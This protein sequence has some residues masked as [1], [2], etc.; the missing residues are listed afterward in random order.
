[1]TAVTLRADGT[2]YDPSK[3]SFAWSYSKLKNYEI[4][5]LRHNE[6]DNKKST[7]EDSSDALDWGNRLHKVAA[8]HFTKGTPIPTDCQVLIP[9]IAKIKD[10]PGTISVERKY[11]LTRDLSPCGYFGKEVWYRGVA[12]VLKLH[13]DV[14]LAVDWKSGKIV[15]DSVQLALM[16]SCI[17]A[18]HPEVQVIR[19]EFIWLGHECTTQQIF[20]RR[21]MPSL[22][23]DLSPRVARL[24]NSFN[25]GIY[26]PTPN[27]MCA[28]YCRVTTCQHHG[29]RYA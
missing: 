16:A 25:S 20:T 17:F 28:S 15:A 18:H 27:R 29:K 10:K 3:K 2:L 1:M 7:E 11:A 6:T 22:W 23:S 9:W 5:P 14:A 12:D 26:S 21:E 4:C 24:E 13:E 8:E 19:T